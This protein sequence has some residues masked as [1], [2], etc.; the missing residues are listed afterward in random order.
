VLRLKHL[1]F[2]SSYPKPM[3]TAALTLIPVLLMAALLPF[4]PAR[5][6]P[7]PLGLPAVKGDGFFYG[8]MET[9]TSSGWQ[10]YYWT[11]GS[12]SVGALPASGTSGYV[13]WE[14][15]DSTGT[16]LLIWGNIYYSGG[17]VYY[18][19]SVP[20]SGTGTFSLRF[21]GG[22]SYVAVAGALSSYS[23]SINTKIVMVAGATV[24][25]PSYRLKSGAIYIQLTGTLFK[26][27][28]EGWTPVGTATHNVVISSGS[29]ST[30][31][32]EMYAYPYGPG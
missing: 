12:S 10:Y 3:K 7:V 30:W 21:T 1:K 8:S 4:A 29:L 20:T 31:E 22:T 27:E 18:N 13:Y 23:S 9:F 17:G 5:A 26:D 28:G 2:L 19:P 25:D 11:L 24:Y 6:G 15:Q 32:Y 14:Y 16:Y